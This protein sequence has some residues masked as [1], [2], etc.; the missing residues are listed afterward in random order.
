MPQQQEAVGETSPASLDALR[1]ANLQSDGHHN[2]RRTLHQCMQ[3][4]SPEAKDGAHTQCTNKY[5]KI[6]LD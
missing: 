2:S 1:E 6:T 5:A 3:T 4:I